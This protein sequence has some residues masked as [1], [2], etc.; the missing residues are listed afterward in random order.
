MKMAV[1]IPD[2]VP[3]TIVYS[4]TDGVVH[5]TSCIDRSG[6]KNVENVEVMSSHCGMGLNTDVLKVVADRLARAPRQSATRLMPV[7][8]QV[9]RREATAHL[10]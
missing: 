7:V 5:W 3:A 9:R 4:K 1:G 10:S 8:R 6:A 2:E